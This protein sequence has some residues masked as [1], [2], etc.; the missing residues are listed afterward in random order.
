[1]DKE[2]LD[3][4]INNSLEQI[5]RFKDDIQKILQR[6]VEQNKREILAVKG[7]ADKDFSKLETLAQARNLQELRKTSPNV[8]K[9]RFQVTKN[10]DAAKKVLE[11]TKSNEDR[12]TVCI[13]NT[14]QSDDSIRFIQKVSK[15]ELKAINRNTQHPQQ[16]PQFLDLKE[17]KSQNSFFD[18]TLLTFDEVQNIKRKFDEEKSAEIF[19][20]STK[21]FMNKE[22]EDPANQ[23]INVIISSRP[24]RRLRR[25]IKYEIPNF[26]V[27]N[28]GIEFFKFKPVYKADNG[29]I[30]VETDIKEIKEN[31]RLM[32]KSLEHEKLKFYNY[33]RNFMTFHH[34]IVNICGTLYRGEILEYEEALDD[35]I[36]VL[37][38]DEGYDVKVPKRELLSL[39]IDF[40]SSPCANL[41]IKVK[42]EVDIFQM[43]E[44]EGNFLYAKIIEYYPNYVVVEVSKKYDLTLLHFH[45][46]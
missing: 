20:R 35:N 18:E 14:L 24:R 17:K 32:K 46:K 2:N 6:V 16:A 4:N 21:I 19:K 29:I 15:L 9:K 26:D 45:K 28:S 3:A 22:E 31:A 30:Y 33:D 13:E 25:D 37:L 7:R 11:V 23:F 1:M 44:D 41:R 5:D 43:Y 40:L 36:K 12:K 27:L 42:N 38:V 10:I 34:C 39:P 8:F